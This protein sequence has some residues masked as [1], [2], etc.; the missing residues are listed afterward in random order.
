MSEAIRIKLS[1]ESSDAQTIR[2]VDKLGKVIS[3]RL[4]NALKGT[5]AL[6]DRLER[7]GAG[8]V[9]GSGARVGGGVGG[10]GTQIDSTIQRLEKL[11]VRGAA[12]RK[13]LD[14]LGGS[15]QRGAGGLRS[16]ALTLTSVASAFFLMERAGRAA[17]GTV[18]LLASPLTTTVKR[19]LE[20][21]DRQRV[22]AA[23][24][25]TV[26]GGNSRARAIVGS[27]VEQTRGS[28]LTSAQALDISR[29]A[30][31]VPGLSARFSSGSAQGAAKQF[32]SYA[33][34][35]QKGSVFAPEAGPEGFG[36]GVRE[37]LAGQSQS[38][39][40]RANVAAE[41]IADSIGERLSVVL[42][43]PNKGLR[44][45]S[46]FVNSYSGDD[47]LR[48][49]QGTWSNAKAKLQDNIAQLYAVIGQ[50]SGLYDAAVDRLR[51]LSDSILSEI[52]GP[53]FELKAKRIGQSATR[54]ADNLFGGMAAIVNKLSGRTDPIAGITDGVARLAEV[55]A[56]ASDALPRV[57]D[58]VAMLG[59]SGIEMV[60][61]LSS[62]VRNGGSTTVG[63]AG[64]DVPISVGN[65]RELQRLKQELS[66]AES[67]IVVRRQEENDRLARVA[68]GERSPYITDPRNATSLRI[69]EQSIVDLRKRIKDLEGG[70][71]AFDVALRQII[72]GRTLADL[73]SP[74]ARQRQVEAALD[75][76]YSG[77]GTR[78][79]VQ[80]ITA[81]LAQASG[82]FDYRSDI[83]VSLEKAKAIA[84]QLK[85]LFR[86]GSDDL[87]KAEGYP[88]LL[89]AA[90]RD[91]AVAKRARSLIAETRLDFP[92][93]FQLLRNPFDSGIRT[94][95]AGELL[96]QA[97]GPE[98]SDK[99]FRDQ[100]NDREGALT[101]VKHLPQRLERELQAVSGTLASQFQALPSSV[102]QKLGG[103]LI[104]STNGLADEISD[105]LRL[106]PEIRARLRRSVSDG[107]EELLRFIGNQTYEAQQRAAALGLPNAL[108]A[109]ADELLR[110][111]A[112]TP[113]GQ[114][115]AAN[116]IRD[117]RLKQLKADYKLITQKLANDP[118]NS[119][120]QI[121]QGFKAEDLKNIQA[122]L[123]QTRFGI[124]DVRAS[125]EDLGYAARSSFEQ[126]FSDGIYSAITGIGTLEDA[127]RGFAQS[128][129]RAFADMASRNLVAG[130]FG[131]ALTPGQGTNFGLLGRLFSGI[132][133]RFTGS[134]INSSGGAGSRPYGPPVPT[135]GNGGI[136]PAGQLGLVGFDSRL[137]EAVV[138][139][140]G[141]AFG[142][143]SAIPVEL[144]GHSQAPVN[145]WVVAD[146]DQAIQQGMDRRTDAVVSLIGK[147][148]TRPGGKLRKVVRQ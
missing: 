27:L 60:K 134:G 35:L 9:L 129:I 136:A 32:L 142:G 88:G 100:I 53:E 69:A 139:M 15:S 127:V 119:D 75:R 24:L 133:A 114:T 85:E 14:D 58:A 104:A 99:F 38:I 91:L 26:A 95:T 126:G 113:F 67:Q 101:A 4:E 131:D 74:Y 66:W 112:S 52:A 82:E 143:A 3:T 110:G 140:S 41:A 8:G 121:A 70:D 120:L 89:R 51:G 117:G 59:A 10:M 42:A 21:T 39:R 56:R 5:T 80:A 54:I 141:R 11:G 64:I 46:T 106:P 25:T 103:A 132:G 44:A 107:P 50:R 87:T 124:E 33:E 144:R 77:I 36:V 130:L 118:N 93:A 43:D 1:V 12:A 145:V 68:A 81:P 28:A 6:L 61:R 17:M 148:M 98:R 94:R 48:A 90:E 83:A 135:F 86:G 57:A 34:L 122:E 92:D 31:F 76:Q 62:L 45:I 128:T 47:V 84:P 71:S 116:R 146:I 123:A 96:D 20:E 108:P 78:V 13:V 125:L 73:A 30:A 37:F 137:P 79:S 18:R 109:T 65:A 63:I 23:A 22:A 49:T 102:A 2:Q 105:A 138:P 147:E 19:A 7:I 29:Q 97:F 115:R 55:A 16:F 72:G 40:R 111:G